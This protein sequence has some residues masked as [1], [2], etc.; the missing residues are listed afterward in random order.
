MHLAG[1]Q[2]AP[3]K[4]QLELDYNFWYASGWHTAGF[5]QVPAGTCLT[6]SGIYLAGTQLASLKFQLEL[7]LLI[8]G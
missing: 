7:V 5:P 1:T 3:L 2:L 8:L 4:F 6:T